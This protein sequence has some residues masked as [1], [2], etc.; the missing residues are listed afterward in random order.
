MSAN[1][2]IDFLAA[3]RGWIERLG[4]SLEDAAKHTGIE[5]EK[6]ERLFD[7]A[8]LSTPFRTILEIL[9]GLGLG[10]VGI[11][12]PS[13]AMV[14]RHFE[15]VRAAKVPEVTKKA[16]SERA[17][18]HRTYLISLF[19]DNDAEPKL[20]TILKL[21]AAL[22]HALVIEQRRPL[23]RLVPE[24]PFVEPSPAPPASEHPSASTS[25]VSSD[26]IAHGANVA[27]DPAP[28]AGAPDRSTPASEVGGQPP[29]W[30]GWPVS[31]ATSRP[32][33]A[34]SRQTGAT[35]RQT[36]SDPHLTGGLF[37][38]PNPFTSPATPQSP[39]PPQYDA[40][41]I[42]SASPLPNSPPLYDRASATDFAHHCEDA[43]RT[44]L[45]VAEANHEL[46]KNAQ[47]YEYERRLAEQ[48]DA[49]Q[50]ALARAES[51]EA[52]VKNA[53]IAGGAAATT[54]LAG[55]T[56]LA[57]Q[58]PESRR[59]AQAVMSVT[60][61]AL[62]LAGAFCEPDSKARAVLI[63]TGGALL[64]TTVIDLA[65][66]FTRGRRGGLGVAWVEGAEGLV[67]KLMGPTSGARRAGLLPG[68]RVLRVD[69]VPVEQIGLPEAMARIRGEPGTPVRILVWRPA[70]GVELDVVVHR[71]PL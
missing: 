52:R 11:E 69:D 8:E 18:I 34:T 41:K 57:F 40:P 23:P 56:A 70:A 62:S 44:E 37:T 26:P 4:L 10:L 27:A 64:L 30:S 14:L 35:S 65:Q 71:T 6:L 22:E 3:I 21:A 19:Q 46:A 24:A 58:S 2:A 12:Q 51:S 33:S 32:D 20:E 17:G 55:S 50:T 54:M 59:T 49:T 48:T 67:I 36:G 53:F 29:M 38:G 7:L 16:L 45:R 42:A 25:A 1:E 66:Q 61:G 39:S 68:D 60:G 31:G 9:D 47:R 43:G 15:K 28:S 63:G 5:V 13:P